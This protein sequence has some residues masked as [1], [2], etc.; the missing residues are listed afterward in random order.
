MTTAEFEKLSLIAAGVD[1]SEIPPILDTATW[2]RLLIAALATGGG[3]SSSSFPP[4]NLIDWSED[5]TQP[6]WFKTNV[7]VTG[8][9][10]IAPDGTSLADGLFETTTNGYHALTSAT[11]IPS[12]PSN[13]LR[14]S[15]ATGSTNGVVWNPSGFVGAGTIATNWESFRAFGSIEVVGQGT[16]DG[17]NYV[18]VRFSGNN[19]NAFSASQIVSGDNFGYVNANPGETWTA[20]V[21][22][23]LVGGSLSNVTVGSTVQG[24]NSTN[25]LNTENA[26]SVFTPNSSYQRVSATRAMSNPST[27]RVSQDV[28]VTALAGS[29][30]NVTLRIAA[31]QLER[32]N[33]A[34]QYTPTSG[35]A[36]PNQNQFTA[37][38]FAKSNGRSKFAMQ[39]GILYAEFDLL[40]QTAVLSP[41]TGPSDSASITS[42]G[43]GWFRCS[44]T[45]LASAGDTIQYSVL[46]NG[47]SYSYPGS[48][49]LGVYLWGAQLVFGNQA[50]KYVQTRGSGA[51]IGIDQLNDVLITSPADGDA[52][53]YNN[54]NLW[55]NRKAS[56]SSLTLAAA[57]TTVAAGGQ[58][59]FF[60]IPYDLTLNLSATNRIFQIPFN[61]RIVAANL[62]AFTGAASPAGQSG[63]A[64]IDLHNFTD[65]TNTAM[66]TGV[67]FGITS[68]RSVSYSVTGLSIDVV[69]S[70]EYAIRVVSPTFTAAPA[71]RFYVTLYYTRSS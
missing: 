23:K 21:Y 67:V 1:P 32:N 51:E 19:P 24:R 48:T 35:T 10:A 58:T 30:I 7:T 16:E 33:V 5:F 37:S 61:A 50:G 14:N 60:G 59:Y 54:A 38:V 29:T 45:R 28:V 69:P 46:N 63:G 20:S 70:K 4:H 11:L 18:D 13:S 43:N 36:V 68:N 64:T 44:F 17:F 66:F 40:A 25:T 65:T 6:S 34:S 31:P 47:G 52:L 55:V 53:I 71:L 27:A 2:R 42:A 9:V 22:V 26:N 3:G 8:N 41:G 39:I 49:D 15:Q 62:T 57:T 12:M 56:P